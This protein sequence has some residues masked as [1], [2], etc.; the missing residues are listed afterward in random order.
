MRS[1]SCDST[2]SKADRAK[3]KS[4]LGVLTPAPPRCRARRARA[5]AM[6]QLSRQ[7]L[8]A[9]RLYALT[10]LGRFSESQFW[11]LLKQTRR[12]SAEAADY[13]EWMLHRNAPLRWNDGTPYDP[14]AAEKKQPWLKKVRAGPRHADPRTRATE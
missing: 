9:E 7:E 8:Y 4:S 14:A 5:A 11:T 2:P 6:E 10:R 3:K 12:D 13:L 1:G